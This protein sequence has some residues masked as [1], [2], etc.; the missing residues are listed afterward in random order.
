M[1]RTDG[2]VNNILIGFLNEDTFE[3]GSP[4]L[5]QENVITDVL[6]YQIRMASNIYKAQDCYNQFYQVCAEVK[7]NTTTNKMYVINE[8]WVC[9]AIDQDK[10]KEATSQNKIRL[11]QYKIVIPREI[12]KINSK[13]LPNLTDNYEVNGTVIALHLKKNQK[14]LVAVIMPRQEVFNHETEVVMTNYTM[15]FEPK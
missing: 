1:L 2:H 4:N 7:F 12:N 9:W 5:Q 13:F 8:Y 10:K 6:Q 14:K 3:H 15:V 11:S